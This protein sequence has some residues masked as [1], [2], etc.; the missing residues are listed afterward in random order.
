MCTSPCSGIKG[1]LKSETYYDISPLRIE[2]GMGR[3]D[4]RE[5]R[6]GTQDI[7]LPSPH[8]PTLGASQL[9]KTLTPSTPPTA[10]NVTSYTSQLSGTHIISWLCLW[11]MHGDITVYMELISWVREEWRRGLKGCGKHDQRHHVLYA[12]LPHPDTHT[13][14]WNGKVMSTSNATKG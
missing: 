6:E 1:M 12:G 8:P 5:G 10:N 2:M 7:S 11:T 13:R 9:V 14:R 4:D 3:K